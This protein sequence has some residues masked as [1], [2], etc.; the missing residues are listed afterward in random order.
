MKAVYIEAQGGPEVLTYGD[1]PEPEAQAGGVKVRVKATALNRLDLYTRAGGRGLDREFPPP[2]ILGGDCAGEIVAIGDGVTTLKAGD[3]VVVNPRISCMQCAA[4]LAGQD[5]LC[6]NENFL[7]SAIDGSYAEFV[8]VPAVNAHLLADSVSFEQAAAAPTTYLP[9]WNMLVRK[10][11]LKSWQTVLVLSASAGVGVAAIQ[12]A[13]DIIGA[14]VIATTSSP[15]KAARATKLGADVVINYNEE[16]IRERVRAI[17]G[18]AG[19]D[20]V[21]DHVGADFFGPAFASLRNG[22]RYGICGATTGLRTELHLGQL[23]SQRKEIY[24]VFMGTKEDMREIVE[25]L[26][27]GAVKPVVD[28]TFLLSEAAAAHTYMDETSFFG[29]LILTQD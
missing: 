17:T 28:R 7:G 18:R 27:R 20:C 26:N 19:V 24:G 3:R 23:F 2:L 4:C 1:R 25:M 15:E 5:D 13:K 10:L 21:V 29:K 14:K 22:G 16:D 12:V 9:V 6:R 8:A 11:Q